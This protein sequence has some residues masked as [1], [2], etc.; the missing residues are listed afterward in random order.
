MFFHQIDGMTDE[1]VTG[2]QIRD[3]SIQVAKTIQNL[4]IS[5]GDCVGLFTLNRLEF[6]YVLIGSL[7]CGATL[8][9]LNVTYTSSNYI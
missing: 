4:G 8:A 6:A 2:F 3:R 5:T 1:K 7:M 9:P